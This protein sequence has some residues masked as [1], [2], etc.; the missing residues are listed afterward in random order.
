MEPLGLEVVRFCGHSVV[1]DHVPFSDVRL[2]QCHVEHI[3]LEL[4]TQG[5]PVISG[6]I[7]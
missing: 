6:D 4:E 5:A 2:V 7:N 1:G 3:D